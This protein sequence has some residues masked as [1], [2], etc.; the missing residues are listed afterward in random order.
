[1]APTKIILKGYYGFGNLGDDILMLSMYGWLRENYPEANILI[2]TDSGQASYI[3]EL[4]VEP[5]HVI[6]G[7]ENFQADWIIHGGGGVYFDFKDGGWKFSLLNRIVGWIGPHQFKKLYKRFRSARGTTGIV[8][9]LRAGFGIGVGT[10][11]SSSQKFYAD[12]ND[13]LEFKFLLVRDSESIDNLRKLVISCPTKI[14]SDLAFLDSYWK[15]YY[16]PNKGEKTIGI[17]LRDWVYDNHAYFSTMK[18]VAKELIKEGFILRFFSFDQ[19]TDKAYLQNFEVYGVVSWNP[20]QGAMNLFL[21]KIGECSLVLT[22]RAHGAIVSTCLGIPA[23]CLEIEPKLGHI[24]NLLKHSAILVKQPFDTEKLKDVIFAR[25]AILDSL[26]AM[27]DLDCRE[28]RATMIKGLESFKEFLQQN[29]S[30]K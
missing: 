24:A 7:H 27:I 3:S 15:P 8:G 4:I 18:E 12:I 26:N 28:N 2:C 10:Y 9:S 11:T 1:M 30:I 6:K 25:F 13:L 20:S 21:R 29:D 22:S 16:S 14:S 23:I 5:V 17:I 19:S